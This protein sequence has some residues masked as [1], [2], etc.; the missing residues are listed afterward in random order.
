MKNYFI[1]FK[2]MFDFKGESTVNEFWSF[3]L[4]KIILIILITYIFKKL[5][6]YDYVFPIY[7]TLS[8]VV[9]ISLGFRR[10]KNA[11][12]SG[13]LFLIPFANLILASLPSKDSK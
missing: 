7:S 4:I 3:F 6:I 2:R 9:L 11:G 5:N 8:T 10:L 12:F 13:W 1:A